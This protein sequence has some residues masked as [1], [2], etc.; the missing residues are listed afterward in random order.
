MHACG[1]EGSGDETEGGGEPEEGFALAFGF[2]VFVQAGSVVPIRRRVEGCGCGCDALGESIVDDLQ[3]DVGWQR[4]EGEWGVGCGAAETG[5]GVG[6][7]REGHDDFLVDDHGF[8]IRVGRRDGFIEQIAS[9]FK[10][11]ILRELR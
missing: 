3:E 1:V 11:M 2:G 4:G 5:G 8:M 6:R 9:I 10:V 7:R